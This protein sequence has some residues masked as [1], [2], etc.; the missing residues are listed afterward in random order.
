MSSLSLIYGY[1]KLH[2]EPKLGP[3]NFLTGTFS[4]WNCAFWCR[5]TSY[6]WATAGLPKQDGAGI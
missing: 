4:V 1:H 5:L 2:R 3:E 6:F